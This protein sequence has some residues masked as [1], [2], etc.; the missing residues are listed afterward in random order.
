MKI[1]ISC[2]WCGKEILRYPSQLKEHNFCSRVCMNSFSSKKQNPEGYKYRS[3]ERNSIRFSRMN[4]EQNVT[5]MTPEVRKKLREARLGAG[6]GKTYTKIFGRHEHR[7]IAEQILGRP[8]RP[9][10]IV[11][12]IDGNKRNNRPENLK[13]FDSQQEHAAWHAKL[14]MFFTSTKRGDAE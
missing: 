8:L 13:V 10:E 4:Q 14:T 3:F 1:I 6:E 2:D 7:V 11:H 12:H 5:R 9:N